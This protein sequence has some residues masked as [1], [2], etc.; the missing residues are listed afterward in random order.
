MKNNNKTPMETVTLN[1]VDQRRKA[2]FEFKYGESAYRID[3]L[4]LGLDFDGGHV[5]AKQGGKTTANFDICSAVSGWGSGRINYLDGLVGT[6]KSVSIVG[7]SRLDACDFA[8]GDQVTLRVPE[9]RIGQW[10]DWNVIEP[11]SAG[12]GGVSKRSMPE[13]VPDLG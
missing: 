11:V 6:F 8:P 12:R 13:P 7:E 2:M 10:L 3:S 9:G 5:T 1:V 4:P